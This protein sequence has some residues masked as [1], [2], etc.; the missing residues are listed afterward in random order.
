MYLNK[1]KSWLNSECNQARNDQKSLPLI[2]AADS[3]V[4][5]P[6]LWT[7]RQ[8]SRDPHEEVATSGDFSS[9]LSP[10]PSPQ[11]KSTAREQPRYHLAWL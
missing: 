8:L 1:H 2:D 11:L 9:D 3:P 10:P 6:Q 7:D 5:V 4:S